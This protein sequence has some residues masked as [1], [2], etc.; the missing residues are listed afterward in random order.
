MDT[1]SGPQK[2]PT[3]AQDKRVRYMGTLTPSS[4]HPDHTA[5]MAYEHG[6]FAR[7]TVPKRNFFDELLFRRCFP[8]SIPCWTST[9]P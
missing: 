7:F 2:R 1:T 9:G 3:G 8:P 4:T 5:S 6:T